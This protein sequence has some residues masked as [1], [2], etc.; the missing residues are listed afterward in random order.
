MRSQGFHHQ[1]QKVDSSRDLS[2]ADFINFDTLEPKLEINLSL[3]NRIKEFDFSMPDFQ[4]LKN[5]A[6]SFNSFE[7]RLSA[8]EYL[9]SSGCELKNISG[10]HALIFMASS[11]LELKNN[12]QVNLIV[13]ALLDL[14]KQSRFSSDEKF[15]QYLGKIIN[16]YELSQYNKSR[17]FTFFC[18]ADCLNLKFN[19]QFEAWI[20]FVVSELNEVTCC[21]IGGEITTRSIKKHECSGYDHLLAVL[22]RSKH[23]AANKTLE[24]LILCAIPDKNYQQS[25]EEVLENAKDCSPSLNLITGSLLTASAISMVALGYTTG[26]LN[27]TEISALVL[28]GTAVVALLANKNSQKL[29]VQRNQVLSDIPIQIR[30]TV[31]TNHNAAIN[32]M[33]EYASEI[34][35]RKLGQVRLFE[36]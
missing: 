26:Q 13:G 6:S 32:A 8:L 30:E 14:T 35:E 12:D 29:A 21:E 18:R 23:Y 3:F 11:G 5:L 10:I 31:F 4:I 19:P 22:E 34:L 17:A 20:D 33:S 25:N 16:S 36:S 24:N 28:I 7:S 2:G 15:I 27:P 9:N 1:I